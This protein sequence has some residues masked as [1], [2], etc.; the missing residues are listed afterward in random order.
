MARALRA[1]IAVG[2][3]VN[4]VE[5]CPDGRIVIVVAAEHDGDESGAGPNPWD[6]EVVH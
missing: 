1:A 3:E 2:I 4:R 6:D 5:V